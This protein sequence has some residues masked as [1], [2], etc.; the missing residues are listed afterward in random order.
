MIVAQNGAWGFDLVQRDCSDFEQQPAVNELAA[1]HV[2]IRCRIDY[3]QV[4]IGGGGN[5]GIIGQGV[6]G[7][8]EIGA[9]ES[10]QPAGLDRDPLAGEIL[11]LEYEHRGF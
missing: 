7:A 6:D 1:A 10:R 3:V 4:Q 5:F 9:Q 2:G 8:H 11:G